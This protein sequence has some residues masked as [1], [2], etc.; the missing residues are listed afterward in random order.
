MTANKVASLASRLLLC[1]LAAAAPAYAANVEKAEV[2]RPGGS[3][4]RVVGRYQG[5]VLYLYG[6]SALG[7]V[8]LLSPKS[9]KPAL[10]E[11]EGKV[12]NRMYVAPKAASPLEV[13]RN[14]RD[15]LMKAGFETIY[16]CELAACV[17]DG[18]QTLMSDRP[19]EAVWIKSN[20]QADS[21]FN[22]GNQPEFSYYSGR[23]SGPDGITYVSIGI[24]GGSAFDGRV[25]QFIQVAEPATTQLGKVK[26][27]AKAIEAGLKR[28]G[29]MALY[30]VNFD[31]NKAVLREDSADQLKEMAAV[32]TATPALKVFIVGHTDNQGEFGANT[33]LSQKRADAV[34]AA[35][36]GR[37]GIAPARLIGRGV[38]NLAP[39]SAN[40]S[41]DGRA[42][43]RRVEMVVR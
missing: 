17:K 39:M 18:T 11:V 15:A 35:L 20:A 33:T 41:E 12:A 31:T 29:K 23:R 25:R 24:A 43:N 4:N 22:S 30:G 1:A 27:D 2:D 37:Y 26:V 5:S 34:V 8:N 6:D 7:K 21:L 14:Y 16:A 42:K 32:L 36:S 40:D 13:Y 38:A 9:G 19:R 10:L 3:D 28:D